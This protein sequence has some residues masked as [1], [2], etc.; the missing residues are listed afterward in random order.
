MCGPVDDIPQMG[1]QML[2]LLNVIFED[3]DL[4][5][6]TRERIKLDDL[7]A[8]LTSAMDRAP[9]FPAADRFVSRLRASIT[10]V[11]KAFDLGQESL[12][13]IDPDGLA[14]AAGIFEA[15]TDEFNEAKAEFQALNVC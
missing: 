10:N 5:A 3:Q 7:A 13:L 15:A 14:A 9:E 12:R 4:Q 6:A 11:L 1:E 2:V 8:D